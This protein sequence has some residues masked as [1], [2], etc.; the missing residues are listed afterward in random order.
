MT[1]PPGAPADPIPDAPPGGTL[2]HGLAAIDRS[3]HGA[4]AAGGDGAGGD[5]ASA[6]RRRRAEFVDRALAALASAAD[7]PDTGVALAAVG[8]YGRRELSP[9]SDLDLVLLH[10]ATTPES[11]AAQLAERLWYPIWDS[12]IQLDHAVRTVEMCRQVARADLPSALGMLD[13]RH[14]AGDPTLTAD[15][16]RAVLADWRADA[17]RRLPDLLASCRAR[18]ARSGDLAYAAVPDLKE[19]RGGL[20]DLAVMRA[21]A[22]SWVADCPHQ[23]LAQARD[24]LLDIRDALRLLAGRATDRVQ[25]QDQD[26]LAAAL[27]LGDRDGLMRRVSGIGRV[28]AHAA[29]LTWFRVGR[30]LAGNPHTVTSRGTVRG[31]GLAVVRR[32]LADGIVEHG[33]E[34]V[35]ARSVDPA[36]DPA[37][38]LRLGAAAALAG[39]PVSPAALARVVRAAPPMPV[40]WP[41][42]ARRALLELLGAGEP[43]AGVWE[44]LDL[45]GVIGTLLPDW[46][47]LRSLPQRDPVHRHTVD[48]HLIQTAI[49]AAALVRRV[50]R[51]DLLLIASLLH[52]IGKGTGC[53]HSVAGARMAPEWLARMGFP[54]DDAALVVTLVRE[55][56]LLAQTAVR[57]DPDD[58][59][60]IESVAAAVGGVATL[61]LLAALTEA[62]ATA[63]GPAA[64]SPWKAA[65]V[66]I[67]VSR[68]RRLLGGDG[69][70][71]GGATVRSGAPGDSDVGAPAVGPAPGGAAPGGTAPGGPEAPVAVRIVRIVQRPDGIAVAVQAPDRHGLL[72]AAAGVFAL[73]R[74][75][76]R[77]ASVFTSETA[78]RQDW[79]V[80]PRF[81]DPPD[82][83]VLQVD[84]VR[85]LTGAWDVP[86]ALARRWEGGS[87]TAGLH[88]EADSGAAAVAGRA[89][90]PTVAVVASASRRSTV[91]EVR[92]RDYPTL[93][94]RV[95]TAVSDVGIDVV[96]ARVDT[97]GADV[98]DAFYLQQGGRPLDDDVCEA[99]VNS[100]TAAVASATGGAVR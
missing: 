22:A 78:A 99:V 26:A 9:H 40:P 33:G 53:D 55:H 63:A 96:A 67:L 62:D 83:A 20:R 43:L 52:D 60:T 17:A 84:L 72:A 86:A 76:I 28:V 92:A 21:V 56:L 71:V 30:V 1:A 88:R 74:L 46:E 14:I 12:G 23:G 59:A 77:S 87:A 73:H 11:L 42:H 50:N 5:G 2:R 94:F 81:G 25:V 66:G 24:D 75:T 100:V 57:R 38:P 31:A 70:A 4:G 45:A 80:A 68:T 95:A 15:L 6:A 54:R 98:V 49:Q 27:G 39:I 93:V 35:L 89:A 64:W 7:V 34:A 65:Q 51:P 90:T 41:E 29:D 44:A 82:P 10:T 69:T 91:L 97:Y 32:P 8:G 85:A 47:R 37:L 16:Q 61:D 13:L 58:P 36:Q 18:A 79:V 48:R 19:S 3:V